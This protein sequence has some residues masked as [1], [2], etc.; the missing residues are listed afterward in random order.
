MS[1]YKRVKIAMP[2]AHVECPVCAAK[3]S[4]DIKQRTDR[5]GSD[6]YDVNITGEC[7]TRCAKCTNY[8][9]VDYVFYGHGMSWCHGVATEASEQ[10]VVDGI[11]DGKLYVRSEPIDDDVWQT[12]KEMGEIDLQTG[13]QLS[14][15]IKYEEP[16]PPKSIQ[17]MPVELQPASSP[18]AA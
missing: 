10:E 4:V 6:Y 2:L 12:G 17:K 5:N 15:G 18:V 8:L 13:K 16:L 11:R 3:L 7:F 14:P 1:W 9:S